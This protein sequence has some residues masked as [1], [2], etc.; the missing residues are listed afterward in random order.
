MRVTATSAMIG[1]R[2][3]TTAGLNALDEL[4]R[5]LCSGLRHQVSGLAVLGDDEE[6]TVVGRSRTYYGKQLATHAVQ[7]ALPGVPLR[8]E[9]VVG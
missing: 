3:R 9:I 5:N 7:T 2:A 1:G 6:L 8:N 4:S